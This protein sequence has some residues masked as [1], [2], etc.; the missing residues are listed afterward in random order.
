MSGR[1]SRRVAR[2][3]I[4]ALACATCIHAPAA[5]VDWMGSRFVYRT[6]GAS[7]ADALHVLAAGQQIPLRIDGHLEGVVSGRFSMPPQRFLDVLGRAYGFV[8]YYDGA[9]LLISPSSAQQSIA[10]RPHFVSASALRASLEQAGVTDSHFPLVVD[11]LAQTV[12]VKGPATYVARIR[13]AAERFEHDAQKRVRT[14]VRVFRLSVA[15]AADEVRMIDGR[16]IV[17][18]G[19][20]TL[21]RRRFDASAAV[22]ADQGEVGRQARGAGAAE[23]VQFDEGL[24]VIEADAVTNSILIRDRAERID[25]DGALVAELDLPA[26][27]ISLQTWVVDVDTDAFGSLA[28]ALPSAMAGADGPSSGAASFG[29]APDRGRAL[30]AQLQALAKSG[31]AGIE[32]SQT[33][34][35]QDR[36]PAVID[37]HEARLAQREEEGESDGADGSADL[38]LSVEPVVDGAAQSVQRIGLQ[39]ELGHRDDAGR[40][41]RVEESVAPGECLVLEGAPRRVETANESDESGRTRIRRRL[42]L[43]IPRVAA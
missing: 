42:V 32:I 36:S 39:V 18:P 41:R 43:L 29:I 34:L 23:V 2:G 40:Y 13:N 17:V 4:A 22:R 38:W 24:P 1:R 9:A 30:L 31:Q 15:N 33:A 26:R 10:I 3:V 6:D 37:R 25:A 28:A 27:L 5:P 35:T 7:V 16:N 20:A 8:W 21:L 19:A 14:T 12:Q 11:S